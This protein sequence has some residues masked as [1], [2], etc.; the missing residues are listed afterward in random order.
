MKMRSYKKP[1]LTGNTFAPKTKFT[2]SRG[3]EKEDRIPG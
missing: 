3:R 1:R 2:C